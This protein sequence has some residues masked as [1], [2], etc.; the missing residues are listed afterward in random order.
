MIELIHPPTLR[1][2]MDASRNSHVLA[3]ALI[4]PFEAFVRHRAIPG[5]QLQL[6]A[7]FAQCTG[8]LD[9]LAVND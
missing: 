3:A 5:E 9:A 7:I 1:K 6:V 4:L 2:R 8:T